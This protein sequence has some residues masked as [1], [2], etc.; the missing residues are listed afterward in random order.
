MAQQQQQCAGPS[1]LHCIFAKIDQDKTGLITLPEFMLF[2]VRDLKLFSLDGASVRAKFHCIDSDKSG[3]LDFSEFC[4]FLQQYV[5]RDGS[6]PDSSYLGLEDAFHVFAKQQIKAHKANFEGG[7]PTLQLLNSGSLLENQNLTLELLSGSINKDAKKILDFWF[8]NNMEEAMTLWFGKS[9]QLDDHLR[10]EYGHLVQQAR[11]GGLDSWTSDPIE[12]LALIVL[13]DQFPRNIFRHKKEMYD[14]DG[15]AQAVCTKALYN[16]YHRYLTPLQTIF[17]PC[18]VLT[19][20]EHLQHQELC[21]DIW[22]HYV[23]NSLCQE[24]PLRIFEMI[25]VKH[26]KVI[27]NYGRFPHRNDIMGRDSTASELDFLND[28]SFRFDLPL[29]YSEDGKVSFKDF[30]ST[31]DTVQTDA[32]NSQ[33]GKLTEEQIA[34]FKEAFSMLDRDGDGTINT[35]EL[36]TVLRSLGQNPTEAELQDMINEVD[37]DGNGTIDFEEFQQMM[38]KKLESWMNRLKDWKKAL[39]DK[40]GTS[41]LESSA[42]K[43][44]FSEAQKTSMLDKPIKNKKELKEKLCTKIQSLVIGN[45]NTKMSAEELEKRIAN[46]KSQIA[47]FN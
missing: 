25:F 22:I 36:G 15:K 13:L 28:K 17:I 47:Y 11:E 35:G 12:C 2:A 6:K 16:N 8:P 44:V 5:V 33:G 31:E 7:C 37:K 41:S 45:N 18:L 38:A 39:D 46:R 42:K 10:S 1:V 24:D 19:H 32:A 3:V 14:S 26:L 4:E 20:S 21:V 29:H 30:G 27:Q 43:E 9:P 40:F 34:E 23:Q